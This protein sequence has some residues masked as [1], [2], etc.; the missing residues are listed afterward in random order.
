MFRDLLKKDLWF[1]H[2]VKVR[3]SP[4]HGLGVFASYDIKK[5]EVIERAPVLCFHKDTMD[6]LSG[7]VLHDYVFAWSAGQVIIALGCG[8]LYN[9]SNDASNISFR[10]RTDLPALEFIAKRDITSGEELLVHYR[11]G[12]RDIMFDTNGGII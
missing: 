8:S 10:A 9:H 11:R 2:K 1:Q 4:L 6:C 12:E 7:H 3:N 5:H